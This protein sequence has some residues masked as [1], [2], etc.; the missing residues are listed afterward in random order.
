M[1][2]F[3]KSIPP[4]H[5]NTVVTLQGL[6]IDFIPIKESEAAIYGDTLVESTT[7]TEMIKIHNLIMMSHS[8]LP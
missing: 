7:V 5:F 1:V 8:N 4:T 6:D 3:G 2:F